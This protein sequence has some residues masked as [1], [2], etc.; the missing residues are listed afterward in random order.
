[1]SSIYRW[2]IHYQSPRGVPSFL[3]FLPWPDEPG[4]TAKELEAG[5]GIFEIRN[6]GLPPDLAD[7]EQEKDFPVDPWLRAR[8]LTMRRKITEK[9]DGQVCLG[10]R[11]KGSS[12]RMPGVVEEIYMLTKACKPVY[13]SGLIGGAARKVIEGFRTKQPYEELFSTA[14]DVEQAYQKHLNLASDEDAQLDRDAIRHHFAE[15]LDAAGLARANYLDP[16]ENR[17]LCDAF[18]TDEVLGLIVQGLRRV[19]RAKCDAV[20]TDR[21]RWSPNLDEILSECADRTKDSMFLESAG[22]RDARPRMIVRDCQA[23]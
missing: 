14:S 20:G 9:V 4:L 13:I 6:V 7:H 22:L 5:A 21:P 11:T 15:T 8:A 3:N 17:R 2:A 16:D 10:G 19:C 18:T 1:M 23:R 12:G